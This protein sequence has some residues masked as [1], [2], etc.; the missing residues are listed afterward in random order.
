[1]TGTTP[2][3]PPVRRVRIDALPAV[4][5]VLADALHGG[6]LASW[7]VPDPARRAEIYPGY[8]GM[9]AEPLLTHGY[10]NMIGDDAVACWIHLDRRPPPEPDGY[11]ARLR[12]VCGPDHP[13]FADLDAAIA[14]NHPLDR[15]HTY[16]AF[17]AVRPAAQ[18]RGLGSALLGATHAHLDQLGVPA[19]LEATG[20]RNRA[21]YRRHGYTDYG[22][23]FPVTRGGPLL[24]PMWRDPRT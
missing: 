18:R 9:L 14:L 13:R 5:S 7:L 22:A 19:Y 21:L 12:A 15:P 24:Y 11:P 23:P 2:S 10:V 4:A 16:L 3:G 1:M 20:D 8:L 6:D 17:L